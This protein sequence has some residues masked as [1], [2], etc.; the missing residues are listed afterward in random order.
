MYLSLKKLIHFFN[1]DHHH[2]ENCL[3]C[4]KKP[5]SLYYMLIA[6][7]STHHIG[8][9]TDVY[10]SIIYRLHSKEHSELYKSSGGYST[11]LSPTN[12]CH[13]VHLITIRKAENAVQVI[14]SL[15]TITNKSLSPHYSLM[16]SKKSWYEGYG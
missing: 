5:Y 6:G 7:H 3:Y 12:I 14:K 16:T 4:I 2:H 1:L 9:I 8:S 13:A 10:A 11:K 15:K